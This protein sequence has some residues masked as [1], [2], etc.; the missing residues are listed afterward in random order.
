MES[1]VSLEKAIA[2][3]LKDLS[4]DR[5]KQVLDFVEFLCSKDAPK[6]FKH[7][8]G[9]P[10]SA[11]E[12]AGDLVGCL[13]GEPRDLSMKK[14]ELKRPRKEFKHPDG[15]PMSALEAAKEFAG[16]LDGEPRDLSINKKY[17]QGTIYE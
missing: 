3:K 15:T 6:E 9:T 11:L 14:Q 7:P 1:V 5:Q 4:G 13:D 2:E 8:D 17:L 12:A 10:M 16:C